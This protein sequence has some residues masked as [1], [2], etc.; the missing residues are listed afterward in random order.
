MGPQ[1]EIKLLSS[2]EERIECGQVKTM[3][4]TR[5]DVAERP[6]VLVSHRFEF[7]SQS[8][9]FLE[10][11]CW[12]ARVNGKLLGLWELKALAVESNWQGTLPTGKRGQ[13][14][15]HHIYLKINS[16]NQVPQWQNPMAPFIIRNSLGNV[17]FSVLKQVWIWSYFESISI[18]HFYLPWDPGI[19]TESHLLKKKKRKKL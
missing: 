2:E 19:K 10:R 8:Y 9:H 4:T 14:S 5:R 17:S 16:F 6:L 12:A 3:S 11:P 18:Q 13:G 7:K 15:A 1:R